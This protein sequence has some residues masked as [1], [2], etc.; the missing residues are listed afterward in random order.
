MKI[1]HSMDLGQLAAL[2]GPDARPDAA[3]G[4]HDALLGAGYTDTDEVSRSLAGP[5]PCCA[6]GRCVQSPV[7]G[8]RPGPRPLYGFVR[9]CHAPPD[10][11]GVSL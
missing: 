4:M 7:P 2:M 10:E 11:S 8:L 3:S 6:A 9:G 1:S 5:Q